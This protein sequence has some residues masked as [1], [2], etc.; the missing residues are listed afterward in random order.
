MH[1]RATILPLTLDRV[2]YAHG[3][4]VLIDGISTVIGASSRTIILGPNGA[5]K[6]LLLR[7][8]HGLI[9][10]TAGADVVLAEAEAAVCGCPAGASEPC[11]T[12]P[13]VIP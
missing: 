3:S 6:S 12:P 7:L 13:Q 1:A 8:C 11:D 10:P 9:A 2:T 5:G 4:T